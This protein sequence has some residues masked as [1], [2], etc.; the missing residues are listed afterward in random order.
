MTLSSHRLFI[1]I[2]AFS[3]IAASQSQPPADPYKPVLDRLQAV[4]TMPLTKWKAINAEMPHGE[5]P[6]GETPFEPTAGG[7]LSFPTQSAYRQDLPL[8]VWLYSSVEVPQAITGFSVAGSRIAL[9]LG[10]GSNTGIMI[11]V[12]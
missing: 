11:T 5:L 12:F 7:V 9:D 3:A 8:P 6:Y 10:I 4:T 1:V 2:V